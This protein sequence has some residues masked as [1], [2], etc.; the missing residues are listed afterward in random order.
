ML[1]NVGSENVG[2]YQLFVEAYVALLLDS[3]VDDA[4]PL[5]LVNYFLRELVSQHPRKLIVTYASLADRLLASMRTATESSITGEF[6]EEMRDTPIFREYLHFFKTG[7]AATLQFI[8]SFLYFGKK[9]DFLDESLEANAFRDWLSIERDLEQLRPQN[10]ILDALRIIVSALVP[11]IDD[12]LLLPRH[13]PGFVSEGC[14]DP[15]D[16]L[17]ILSFD[18]KSAYVF[19][20]T[21]FGRDGVDR[22][23]LD[24]FKDRSMQEQVAKLKFVPKNVKTMR[25]ICMESASRMYL[26]QEVARWLINAM[27]N[28]PLGSMVTLRDQFPS[29]QYAIAGSE[30]GLVDTIDLSAAS[31]RLSVDVVKHIFP[32][33]IL[34]YLLGTRT[35]KVATPDGVIEL[36]KFAPMGSALCFPVQCIVYTAVTIL[37]SIMQQHDTTLVEDIDLSWREFRNVTR[38]ISSMVSDPYEY[39]PHRLIRPRVYGDDIACDNRI[40]SNVLIL[41]SDLGFVVNEAKSFIGG[42]PIRESCGVYAFMGYTVTPCLFRVS[43]FVGEITPSTYTSAIDQANRFGDFGYRRVRSCLIHFLKKQTVGKK[44]PV[45]IFLPFVDDP[46]KFGIFDTHPRQGTKTRVNVY[47]QRTEVKALVVRPAGVGQKSSYIEQYAYDQWMR[48]RIRGGSDEFNYSS[49][50]VRPPRTRFKLDWTPA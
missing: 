45:G 26:Q 19:R 38:F 49:S 16:K 24:P 34:F 41:L 48:A 46:D 21:S 28:G 32:K 4:K 40:T 15:N 13:G 43:G 9:L 3:P 23:S 6:L 35:R 30:C 20:P 39:Q 17:D 11:S 37:A 14:I 12:T 2:L 31:D 42:T 47:L 36:K 22:V 7:D 29:Q 18:P 50:R 27:D 25:S 5:R 10:I 44:I 33:Q 1:D 8:L